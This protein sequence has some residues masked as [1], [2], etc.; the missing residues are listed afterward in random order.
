MVPQIHS[1][2]LLKAQLWLNK[3]KMLQVPKR[4][5]TS[6][7]SDESLCYFAYEQLL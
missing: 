6:I 5:I 4:L 2:L 1:M 3:P 7:F